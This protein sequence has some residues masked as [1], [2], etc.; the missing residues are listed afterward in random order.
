MF[1]GHPRAEPEPTM[2]ARFAFSLLITITLPAFAAESSSDS[3]RQAAAWRAEHR[4]IDLHQH[5]DYKPEL[6]ARAIKIMDAGWRGN[7][8]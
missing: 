2:H 3:Q 1:H 4:T 7:W 5:L 8:S 6:L